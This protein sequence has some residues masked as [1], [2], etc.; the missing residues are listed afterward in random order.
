MIVPVSTTSSVTLSKTFLVEIPTTFL[1]KFAIL[2]HL[3][4]H[5]NHHTPPSPMVRLAAPFCVYFS[6]L[7][8]LRVVL[9]TAVTTYILI[10]TCRPSSGR[11]AHAVFF[12]S[13]GTFICTSRTFPRI[14]TTLKCPC[15]RN[16][17]GVVFCNILP[18]QY[19]RISTAHKPSTHYLFTSPRFVLRFLWKPISLYR[20][21]AQLDSCSL[22]DGD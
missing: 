21:I 9:K 5:H 7:S 3:R 8:M 12:F 19:I 17:L 11:D 18:G 6:D 10:S 15:N 13:I 1:V 20:T 2:T 14:L 16:R 4:P 22:C